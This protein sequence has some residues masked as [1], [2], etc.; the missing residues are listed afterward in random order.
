MI[1]PLLLLRLLILISIL[2]WCDSINLLFEGVE[3][4]LSDTISSLD[5]V[6]FTD[7]LSGWSRRKG[8]GGAE[9]AQQQAE[10][11]DCVLW[12]LDKVWQWM[13]VV[14]EWQE[15][16][17]VVSTRAWWAVLNI[18]HLHFIWFIIGTIQVEQLD[19]HCWSFKL[20][21]LHFMQKTGVLRVLQHLYFY[22]IFIVH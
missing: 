19:I 11:C 10:D 7:S 15:E 8:G 14:T 13:T 4:H 9:L 1:L 20:C 2:I 5:Y 3:Q 21:T 6:T 12:Q 18:S 22:P 16:E 17:E